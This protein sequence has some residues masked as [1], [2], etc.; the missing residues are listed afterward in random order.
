MLGLDSYKNELKPDE[1]KIQIINRKPN[2]WT[3]QNI[4]HLFGIE[5]SCYSK[6]TI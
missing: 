5:W 3:W 6:Y 2:L 4:K 1:E